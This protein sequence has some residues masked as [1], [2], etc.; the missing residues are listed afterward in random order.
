VRNVKS[1]IK[2]REM[3]AALVAMLAAVVLAMAFSAWA[4][5]SWDSST[6]TVTIDERLL[7]TEG[8][9]EESGL[10]KTIG[11]LQT[12]PNPTA[13][14]TLIIKPSAAPVISSDPSAMWKGGIITWEDMNYIGDSMDHV[15]TIDMRGA[16]TLQGSPLL[17]TELW[18]TALKTMYMPEGITRITKDSFEDGLPKI[19]TIVFPLTLE[20]ILDS[21]QN[22]G[23]TANTSLTLVFTNPTPPA[24]SNDAFGGSTTIGKVIVPSGKEQPYKDALSEDWAGKITSVTSITPSPA[25]LESAGGSVSVTVSGSNLSTDLKIAVDG[26]VV[27]QDNPIASTTGIRV[28]GVSIDRNP[29]ASDVKHTLTVVFGDLTVPGVSA[30]VT[31]KANVIRV[32]SPDQIISVDVPAAGDYVDVLY[33]GDVTPNPYPY[34]KREGTILFEY[35]VSRFTTLPASGDNSVT[36]A[37]NGLL[38]PSGTSLA[39]TFKP[40]VGDSTPPVTVNA[41]VVDD[42]T[43]IVVNTET[44]PPGNYEVTFNSSGNPRFSGTLSNEYAHNI[45]GWIE[46][47][48]SDTPAKGIMASAYLVPSGDLLLAPPG[49]IVSFAVLR[50]NGIPVLADVT[51]ST[52]VLGA[53]DEFQL[54]PDGLADDTY[55]VTARAAGFGFASDDVRI[56][57]GDIP[58]GPDPTRGGGGGCSAGAASMMA[59]AGAALVLWNKRMR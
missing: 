54:A 50:S 18:F 29:G 4:T 40:E 16:N 6:E 57:S 48:A 41:T 49:V 35:P 30:D 13:I 45:S 53:V 31:V 58:P 26:N 44:L 52:D 2:K 38:I 51:K 32:S 22:V 46:L 9:N 36:F 28:N 27:S 23:A 56:G 20:T 7:P 47:E 19:E 21:F 37:A 42:K 14:K 12:P 3:K 34:D 11:A 59:L 39:V 1:V 33:S 15:E 24:V 8:E 25:T 17:V 5:N 10:K 55:I 43:R